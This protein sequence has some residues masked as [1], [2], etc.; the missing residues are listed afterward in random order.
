MNKSVFP[1]LDKDLD[2]SQMEERVRDLWTRTGVYAYDPNS[3]NPVFSVDTP[4][5]YLSLIHI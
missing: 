5:P 3:K 2:L 4:P 1:I